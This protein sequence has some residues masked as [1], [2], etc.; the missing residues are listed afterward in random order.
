MPP[1]VPTLVRQA[2]SLL[3]AMAQRVLSMNPR[4]TGGFACE[5]HGLP[6]GTPITIHQSTRNPGPPSAESA[7]IAVRSAYNMRILTLPRQSPYSLDSGKV[8][9]SKQAFGCHVR[10]GQ[11]F[12]PGCV[13]LSLTLANV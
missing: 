12:L 1:L 11:Q 7:T 13:P 9:G 4:V 8:G 3:S 2:V 6:G 5:L 10:V